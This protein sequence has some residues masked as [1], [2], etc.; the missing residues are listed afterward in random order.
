[1][2]D[3]LEKSDKDVMINYN[4]LS[5]IDHFSWIDFYNYNKEICKKNKSKN[6][7]ILNK[8]ECLDYKSED[9]NL[10]KDSDNKI[11]KEEL[12]LKRIEYFKNL[13]INS[14]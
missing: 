14:K 9:K 1:M 4:K 7:N 10:L 12:R 3:I 13:D 11:S 6:D 2:L 8:D 5:K